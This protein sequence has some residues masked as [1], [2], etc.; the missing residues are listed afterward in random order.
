[1]KT[2]WNCVRFAVIGFVWLYPITVSVHAADTPEPSDSDEMSA[3]ARQ[4]P[5]DSQRDNIV[6]RV[7]SPV[8]EAVADINLDLAD[9]D[10]GSAGDSGD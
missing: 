5:A 3:G 6:D 2:G 10:D 7:F 9:G 8:D 1:M 4:S